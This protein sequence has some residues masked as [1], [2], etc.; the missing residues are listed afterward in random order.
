MFAGA[1][2]GSDLSKMF[3]SYSSDFE[4]G[5]LC[6]VGCAIATTMAQISVR[7]MG[8]NYKINTF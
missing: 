5:L 6:A 4:L 8:T 3:N 2:I 7:H 1:F